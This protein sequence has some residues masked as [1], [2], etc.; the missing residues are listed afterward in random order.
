M[1]RVKCFPV[2]YARVLAAMV[3]LALGHA[4]GTVAA[5]AGPTFRGDPQAVAE[6]MSALQK[7]GAARSWRSRMTSPDGTSTATEF[8]APDRFRMVL[9]QGNQT[10]EIF[11]IG[12][13]TWTREGG[14]CTKLPA[15][16]PVTNPKDLAEQTGAETITVTRGNP[17][18]VDGT[19]TQ[20][21][22]MAVESRGTTTRQKLYVATATGLLRRIEAQASQGTLLI[23]YFDYGAPITINPPC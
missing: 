16:I 20:T 9:S 22:T 5:Q 1:S 19:P 12:R 13:E 11:I 8:V 4:A 6:V 21:Y 18:R 14:T 10:T 2:Q 15:T 23:D 7:F 3:A 17:E